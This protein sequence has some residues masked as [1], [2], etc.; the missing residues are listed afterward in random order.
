MGGRGKSVK[1]PMGKKGSK[2]DD[3]DLGPVG[4][5]GLPGPRGAPGSRGERFWNVNI[6]IIVL[7]NIL[8]G[9]GV[10][11]VRW[12]ESLCPPQ[13]KLLHKGLALNFGMKNLLCVPTNSKSS[14]SLGK[15]STKNTLVPVTYPIYQNLFYLK[16]AQC[17]AENKSAMFVQLGTGWC[18][19]GWS[20]EYSGYAVSTTNSDVICL[21]GKVAKDI[22]WRSYLPNDL[23]LIDISCP[24]ML[25]CSGYLSG[26]NL[27]CAVCTK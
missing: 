7:L 8:A 6:A 16:C 12:G 15:G 4:N 18:P 10:T 23:K 11:F 14:V 9:L 13:S 20:T 17:Y 2:G 19:S 22:D 3:G 27:L 21:N 24:N 25:A 5:T 26:E 1:G